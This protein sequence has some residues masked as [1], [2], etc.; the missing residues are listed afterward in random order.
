M[1]NQ[2]VSNHYIFSTGYQ[3]KWYCWRGQKLHEISV[4]YQDENQDICISGPYMTAHWADYTQSQKHLF[5]KRE[6]AD[7]NWVMREKVEVRWAAVV[8]FIKRQLEDDLVNRKEQW[9]SSQTSLPDQ[10]FPLTCWETLAKPALSSC[11]NKMEASSLIAFVDF[12]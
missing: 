6:D 10:A 12:N 3:W 11:F 7:T 1:N 5:S 2:F 9:P 8:Q 4:I